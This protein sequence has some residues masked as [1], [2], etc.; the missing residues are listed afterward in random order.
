MAKLFRVVSAKL[1]QI[2]ID[3]LK[4]AGGSPRHSEFPHVGHNSW[5]A[6]YAHEE[7]YSWFLGHAKK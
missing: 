2:M 5:D 6:A 7:L 3:A 1:S 4:K